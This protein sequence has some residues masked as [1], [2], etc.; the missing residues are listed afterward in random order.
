M[1]LD[2]RYLT[3]SGSNFQKSSQQKN[4]PKKKPKVGGGFLPFEKNMRKSKF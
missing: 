1:D 3:T 2:Y 4:P